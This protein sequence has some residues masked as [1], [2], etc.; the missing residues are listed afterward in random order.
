MSLELVFAAIRV[1]LRNLTG[2][3]LMDEPAIRNEVFI[4]GLFCF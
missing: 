2:D 1:A 4:V 3:I